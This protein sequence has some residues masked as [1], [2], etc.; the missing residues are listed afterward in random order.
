MSPWSPKGCE[1]E[2]NQATFLSLCT[3]R[4]YPVALLVQGWEVRDA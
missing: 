2:Y 4:P 3:V 1:R